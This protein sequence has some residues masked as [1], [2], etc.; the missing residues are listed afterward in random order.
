MALPAGVAA[1]HVMTLAVTEYPNEAAAPGR[2][3]T[4]GQQDQYIFSG[5]EQ[6]HEYYRPTF[7]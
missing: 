3:T 5:N 7:I 6:P 1:G 2:G 4:Y